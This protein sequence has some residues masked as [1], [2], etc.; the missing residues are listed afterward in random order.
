LAQPGEILVSE[1]VKGLLAG[2]GFDLRERGAYALKGVP[3]SWSVYSV[4]V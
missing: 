3:G 2:A 4:A 1:T